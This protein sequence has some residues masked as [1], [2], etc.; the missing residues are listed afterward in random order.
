MRYLERADDATRYQGHQYTWIGWDELTQWASAEAY[1]TLKACLRWAETDVPTKRIRA[2]GNPGGPGH[3]WVK[4][5]FIDH[6]PLGYEPYLDPDTGMER[7]FIPSRVQDNKILLDRDPNYINRLRGVGSPELVRAWLE[8]DWSVVTGAFFPEFSPRH[9][10]EPFEIPEHWLRFVSYDHG[11]ARPFS[12]GWWAV[13]DGTLD[14][15]KGALIRYREWYGKKGP[16]VGAGLKV[17]EIANGILEREGKEKITYRK[18]DPSI[19]K[20]EGGPSIAELFQ[21]NGIVFLRADNARLAGWAQMR[22][23]FLGEDGHPMVYVFKT[24]TDSIRTI[25]ALQHDDKKPEDLDTDGEDHAA[26]DW[27]YGHMSRPWTR[28]AK[29]PQPMKT[30]HGMTF[31]DLLKAE[32]KF[33]HRHY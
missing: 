23:R 15:P 13:S 4:S 3:Q 27:R 17:W 8:G 22:D 11:F 20:Q 28:V 33:K 6:A 7:M 30:M 31:E 5:Y 24:C 12:V 26:D 19:F 14:Y 2:S 29:D 16:N 21:Q 1:N 25:P 10:I 18:A 9:I 32:Q